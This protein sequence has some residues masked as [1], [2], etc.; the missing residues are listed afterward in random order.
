MNGDY[1]KKKGMALQLGESAPELWA[2]FGHIENG[3]E[4]PQ[5]KR[6]ERI[7]ELLS[8]LG[9]NPRGMEAANVTAELGH[10]LRRYR[11]MTHALVSL[12]KQGYRSI[13]R[14]EP[15]A[16]SRSREDVW[17]YEAVASLLDLARTQGAISKLR[18]CGNDE[19]RKWLFVMKGKRR[20][21]DNNGVCKQRHFDSDEK[22]RE[23]KRAKMR[24]LYAEARERNARNPKNGIGLR[25]HGKA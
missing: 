18:R 19:C 13:F 5:S 14:R 4:T 2:V 6:V 8:C 21:C 7:L 17:E 12:T 10:M 9:K 3:S 20:F 25:L 1:S 24:E 16:K 22:Q 11:W 15:E 23:K